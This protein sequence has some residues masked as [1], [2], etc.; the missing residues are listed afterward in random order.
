MNSTLDQHAAE[1]ITPLSIAAGTNTANP[2]NP[3]QLL[4]TRHLVTHNPKSGLNPI[5]D[6]AGNLFTIIGK[7]KSIEAYAY[8]DLDNLH[9]ELVN[10]IV[11]FHESIKNHGYSSEYTLVCR[12]LMCAT[13]D[14]LLSQTRFGK[15]GRW[16]K[17][18]LLLAFEQDL[19]H[20]E[21][22][23][24][25]MGRIIKEPALYIDMM[26]LMY[27][28]LSMEYKG[29]YR[30]AENGQYRLEQIINILYKHIRKYRGNFSKVLSPTQL[31]S[32]FSRRPSRFLRKTS[33]KSIFIL[34]AGIVLTIVI[35][36]NY[37][38]DV[39]TN[40]PT[41]KKIEQSGHQN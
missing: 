38:M 8:I 4:L 21:K 13:L 25:I 27:L 3:A 19:Q 15:D 37:L 16:D 32:S 17:Y 18:S 22:F 6:A 39:I 24:R 29:R 1:D 11:Q 26:E 20:Q 34:T 28:C 23:F 12:Y 30:S 36:L 9:S 10:Q 5:T 33:V 2:L 41:S 14:E 40:E 35:S 7:L 31:K